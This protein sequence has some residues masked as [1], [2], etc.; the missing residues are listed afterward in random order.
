MLIPIP[1]VVESLAL[2]I[3]REI[4]PGVK[5]ITVTRSAKGAIVESVNG[6]PKSAGSV[7]E[8]VESLL[9]QLI[10]MHDHSVEQKF[11]YTI[12]FT[13]EDDEVV[14]VGIQP[15]Y[16]FDIEVPPAQLELGAD[17]REEA[18]AEDAAVM[19]ADLGNEEET[20]DPDEDEM[21][22]VATATDFGDGTGP[23]EVS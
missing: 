13:R 9:N 3:A 17:A 22:D 1:K 10:V 19:N 7:G 20:E 11:A 15:S 21:P 18:A 12:S 23:A 14:V 16:R 2:K 6:S 8:A 4:G 5:S